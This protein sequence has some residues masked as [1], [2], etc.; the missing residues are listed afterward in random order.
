MI[1][2]SFSFSFSLFLALSSFLLSD[3]FFSW[4]NFIE[5]IFSFFLNSIE[6]FSEFDSSIKFWFSLS[7]RRPELLNGF[8][9]LCMPA[10]AVKHLCF[11]PCNSPVDN[12]VMIDNCSTIIPIISESF[13]KIK[14]LKYVC[15]EVMSQQNDWQVIMRALEWREEKRTCS[16]T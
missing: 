6:I 5:L 12:Y 14:S 13:K 7:D 10:P 2:D 9:R 16:T 15:I 1:L 11:S 4:A 3:M 8:K